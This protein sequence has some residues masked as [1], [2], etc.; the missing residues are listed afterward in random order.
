M[1]A[2]DDPWKGVLSISLLA[3]RG[4]EGRGFLRGKSPPPIY[5]TTHP[6]KVSESCRRGSSSEIANVYCRHKMLGRLEQVVPRM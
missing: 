1:R 6:I 4:V 5:P 2:D 3:G